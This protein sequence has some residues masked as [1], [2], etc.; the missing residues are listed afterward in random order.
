MLADNSKFLKEGHFKA[1]TYDQID[2]IIT[3]QRLPKKLLNII[4]EQHIAIET[5]DD[6]KNE[7]TGSPFEG[8]G[9]QNEPD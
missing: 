9:F 8:T 2:L 3:D 5:I 1:L 6:D 7:K 4:D